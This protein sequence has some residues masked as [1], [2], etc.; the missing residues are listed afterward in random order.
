MQVFLNLIPQKNSRDDYRDG[1]VL[2]S[3][4]F[5]RKGIASACDADASPEDVQGYQD[6]LR[7]IRSTDLSPRVF[8]PVLVTN[9]CVLGE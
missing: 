4:A 1:A 2:I 9:G 8:T 6:D 3:K 7:P 5:T